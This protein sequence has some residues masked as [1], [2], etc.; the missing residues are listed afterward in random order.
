MFASGILAFSQ[1]SATGALLG[2]R[3]PQ[4][5]VQKIVQQ[6]NANLNKTQ[7]YDT[8]ELSQRAKTLLEQSQK[9]TEDT[10]KAEDSVPTLD[11]TNS[12]MIGSMTLAEHTESAL[13]YQRGILGSFQNQLAYLKAEADYTAQKIQELQ[14]IADGS[15]VDPSMSA[16]EAQRQIDGYLK[17]LPSDYSH[18]IEGSFMY[19]FYQ[20]ALEKEYAITGG[21]AE[22]ISE[23]YLSS[24]T[25]ESLGL[26]NL[27][28]DP[29]KLA[30]ALENA[31]QKIQ[32]MISS[33]EKN[34]A[35]A[36]GGKTFAAMERPSAQELAAH[37]QEYLDKIN[38]DLQMEK[39]ISFDKTLPFQFSIVEQPHLQGVSSA[40]D[41]AT[42]IVFE[43]NDSRNI[44]TI[45]PQPKG[46]SIDTYA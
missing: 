27:P 3:S 8:V 4:N 32:E 1:R 33:I 9:E 17:R 7:S 38:M 41:F 11:Y 5:N 35:Q 40:D 31:S 14:D 36:T 16:E 29:A 18:A 10:K 13:R 26:T 2:I 30:E 25:A 28:K 45:K 15:V 19:G 34:F 39:P 44:D 21:L 23:N 46:A 22:K 42:A 20:N 24:M 43:N 12:P 37:G 6:I